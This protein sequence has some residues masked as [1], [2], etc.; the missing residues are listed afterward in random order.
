MSF[1]QNLSIEIKTCIA[2]GISALIFSLLIGIIYGIAISVVVIRMLIFLPVF[3]A[4]GYGTVFVLKKYIP[5]FFEMSNNA[6][7]D[8]LEKDI[9]EDD[10]NSEKNDSDMEANQVDG[11]NDSGDKFSEMTGEELPQM[12]SNND[13]EHDSTLDAPVG[14]LGK[15]ILKNDTIAKYEPKIMAEAIRTMMIRDDD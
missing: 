14:K 3:G 12:V 10:I 1:L 4:I 15:H 5:E 8:I 6:E 11:A 7:V 13:L 2:F 9:I